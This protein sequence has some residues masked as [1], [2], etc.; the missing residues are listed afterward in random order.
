MVHAL[1]AMVFTMTLGG[2]ENGDKE[3]SLFQ[4]S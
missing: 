3:W 2:N 1:F 4:K